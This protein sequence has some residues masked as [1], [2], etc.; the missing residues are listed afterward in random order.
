MTP[1]TATRFLAF[2]ASCASSLKTLMIFPVN[3]SIPILDLPCPL[4]ALQKLFI[5]ACQLDFVL[6]GHFPRLT[7]L[8]VVDGNRCTV[9]SLHRI[10][11]QRADHYPR[12]LTLSFASVS[13]TGSTTARLDAFLRR[14]ERVGMQHL[15]LTLRNTSGATLPSRDQMWMSVKLHASNC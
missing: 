15:H 10:L 12:L 5:D 11:D 14:A 2:L 13:L 9:A 3:S 7:Y 8:H 1:E 6:N 4:P